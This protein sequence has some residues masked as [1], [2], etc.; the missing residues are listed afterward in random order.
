MTPEAKIE[1]G[2]GVAGK[3]VIIRDLTIVGEVGAVDMFGCSLEDGTLWATSPS[4]RRL[5]ELAF[6]CGA[7]SVRHD[8]SLVDE[9]ARFHGC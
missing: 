9:H 1:P 3:A 8:Y 6:D 2:I 5:A 7:L 4:P